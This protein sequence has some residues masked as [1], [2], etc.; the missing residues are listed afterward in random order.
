MDALWEW[1]EPPECHVPTQAGDPGALARDP[2]PQAL[3]SGS[4]EALE[5][6]GPEGTWEDPEAVAL[7]EERIDELL[8]ELDA[9][10][11]QA[12]GIFRRMLRVILSLE[13]ERAWELWGARDLPHFISLRYGVSWW[14][15][16]RWVG[17]ARAL[18]GLPLISR[19][20]ERGELSPDQAVELARFARPE[21]EGRLLAWAK[22]VS[23]QAVR[24]RGDR[25]RPDPDKARLA[26][27]GRT[28]EWRY[29]DEGRR[30]ELLADLPAADGALV[31][32]TIDALARRLPPLPEGDRPFSRCRRRADALVA[33]CSGPH[34]A[35]AR[36]LL[37]LSSGEEG[38]ELEGGGVAGPETVGRLL[39]QA[40]LQVLLE[41]EG[42]DPLR[43]GR[44][45]RFPP[46][47][48][49]RHLRRRDRECRFPRC[50]ARQYLVAHHLKRWGEGGGTDPSNLLLVCSFHHKL[51]HELGWR[52]RREPSGEVQW[53]FPG[54]AR[55]RPG[56]SPPAAEDLD[57]EPDQVAAM[58]GPPRGA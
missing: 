9:L 41:D 58:R 37:H 12:S 28:L 56:P 16:R 25:S 53:F 51:V 13:G 34:P 21:D 35:R 44:R 27:D 29:Y 49:L 7:D 38:G 39:C 18:E 20:L 52:V 4:P 55:Y 47:W 1:E 32:G 19:A 46:R 33:L 6:G 8:G 14:R 26:E 43:V 57:E 23:V 45:W 36:I 54:G 31:A 2:D 42:G 24:E 30:F 10:H 17:A 11:T 40:T 5:E 3:G 22:G 15:A 48:V 50:G